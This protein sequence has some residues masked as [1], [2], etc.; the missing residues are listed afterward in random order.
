MSYQVEAGSV[1]FLG[2]DDAHDDAEDAAQQARNAV[3]V[4]DTAGVVQPVRSDTNIMSTSTVSIK[5]KIYITFT[6]VA[7]RIGP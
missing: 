2:G 4:Q 5:D 7:W 6:G 3:Q 1:L